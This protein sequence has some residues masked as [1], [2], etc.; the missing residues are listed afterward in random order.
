VPKGVGVQVL[1]WAPKM[2]L[3]AKIVV[4][5]FVAVAIFSAAWFVLVALSRKRI[6]Y[7][8]HSLFFIIYFAI[9][10]FIFL[11][12][13]WDKLRWVIIGFRPELFIPIVFVLFLNFAAYYLGRRFLK[14]PK[15]FIKEN[16]YE[17]SILMDYR[18][19][20]PK[21]MEILFQQIF[22]VLL[23]LTLF[24]T[25]FTLTGAIIVFAVIFGLMHL[26]LIKSIGKFFGEY[27]SIFA[28]LSAVVFPTLII[29]FEYGFVYTYSI[30]LLFYTLS[31]LGLW[32]YFGKR[33]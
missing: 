4:D 1:S 30:H 9:F 28:A 7:I 21:A 26:P 11:F 20:L 23:T 12:T 31:S 22:I 2:N 25:G 27:Y 15:K 5:F 29:K 24:D 32:L 13:F 19:I 8:S 6:N 3:N 14:K 10:S 17:Y 16:P 33:K 18:Y